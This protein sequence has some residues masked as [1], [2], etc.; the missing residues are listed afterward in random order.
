VQALFYKK[1]AFAP[2]IAE[3]VRDSEGRAPAPVIKRRRFT[4][5]D[6]CFTV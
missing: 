1:A 2:K 4:F 6:V 5:Y 3:K